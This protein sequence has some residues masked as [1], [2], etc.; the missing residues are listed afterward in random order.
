M[1][2]LCLSLIM[3]RTICPTT[4]HNFVGRPRAV[5]RVLLAAKRRSYSLRDLP[6]LL[7]DRLSNMTGGARSADARF[8]RHVILIVD[9]ARLILIAQNYR[10]ESAI[11]LMKSILKHIAIACIKSAIG[12][13][14]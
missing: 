11:C 7:F 12:D 4:L 6:L 10:Q 1:H 3:C 8:L 2:G 13:R 5:P 14:L 9:C